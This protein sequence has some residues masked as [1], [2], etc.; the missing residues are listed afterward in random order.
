[1]G[2]WLDTNGEAIYSTRPWKVYGEGPTKVVGGSFNDTATKGYSSQDIRFTTNG[3]DLYAIAF[4]WP[5]DRKLLIKSLSKG[6]PNGLPPPKQIHLLGSGVEIH[7]TQDS[8]GL[9]LTLPP[10]ETGQYAFVFKIS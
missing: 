9:T 2:K 10:K 1:M 4:G 5:A 3:K 8:G 6:S 7:W